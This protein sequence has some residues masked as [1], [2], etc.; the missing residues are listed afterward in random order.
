MPASFGAV[1]TR[2][3]PSADGRLF[4]A[5]RPPVAALRAT[6]RQVSAILG[7]TTGNVQAPR[8]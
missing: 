2:R 1:D 4:E 5:C 8:P 3:Q 6:I 7:P